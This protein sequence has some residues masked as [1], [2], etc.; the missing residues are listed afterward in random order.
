[1]LLQRYLKIMNIHCTSLIF[2]T[3][4]IIKQSIEATV[5]FLLPNAHDLGHTFYLDQ[6]LY[7]LVHRFLRFELTYILNDD[8]QDLLFHLLLEVFY[9]VEFTREVVYERI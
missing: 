1:M 8:R 9:E 3:R 5:Y 6:R 7:E 4:N 2:E